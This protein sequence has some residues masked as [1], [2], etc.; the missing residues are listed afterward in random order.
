L[1]TIFVFTATVSLFEAEIRVAEILY[2]VH[3]K[4]ELEPKKILFV[5]KA[6]RDVSL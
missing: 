5:N 1:N 2:D 4:S 6:R 3:Q